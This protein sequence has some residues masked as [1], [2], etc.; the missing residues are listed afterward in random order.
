[1]RTHAYGSGKKRPVTMARIIK[2]PIR[3]VSKALNL[4]VKGV[5]NFS[6]AY[7]QPRRNTVGVAPKSQGLSRSFTTSRL[8]YND[9]PPE[10][11]LVRSISVGETGCKATNIK[12]R[13]FDMYMIQGHRFQSCVVSRIGETRTRCSFGL[14]KIDEDRSSSF[15]DDNIFLTTKLSIGDQVAM[16]K[17]TLIM[18]R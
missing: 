1:M 6:N 18:T 4:Y 12:L 17:S 5:T 9:Q 13:D 3:A 16:K 14:R 8:P 10:S 15:T 2:T 11:A 7:I